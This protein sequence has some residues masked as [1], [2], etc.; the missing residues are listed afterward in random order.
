MPA[1]A[2]RRKAALCVNVA[3]YLFRPPTGLADGLAL[4]E[5]ALPLSLEGIR[6]N[7]W[8]PR[9]RRC[10][11]RNGS[12]PDSASRRLANLRDR[13]CP[14]HRTPKPLVTRSARRA[15][16]ARRE[17]RLRRSGRSAPEPPRPRGDSARR[18]AH[19]DRVRRAR[20]A[21]RPARRRARGPRREGG[22]RGDDD[23]RQPARVGL[24]DG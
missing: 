22:R 19:R 8:F 17:F 3:A 23:D 11:L 1:T 20:R 24:R 10:T 4:K 6:P 13:Y 16:V 7:Y 5:L 2:G 21:L 9:S 15:I 14:R 12:E 18:Y